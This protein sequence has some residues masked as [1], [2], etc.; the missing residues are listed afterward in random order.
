MKHIA[1]IQLIRF[2]DPFKY[3]WNSNLKYITVHL[4]K[5][6]DREMVTAEESYWCKIEIKRTKADPDNLSRKFLRTTVKH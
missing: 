1:H 3:V 6:Y 2:T 4:F 5:S